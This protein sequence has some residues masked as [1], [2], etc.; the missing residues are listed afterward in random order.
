MSMAELRALKRRAGVAEEAVRIKKERL[1][2]AEQ[3]SETEKGKIRVRAETSCSTFPG[4]LAEKKTGPTGPRSSGFPA[5]TASAACA[6]TPHHLSMHTCPEPPSARGHCSVVDQDCQTPVGWSPSWWN[7]KGCQT[8]AAPPPAHA[9]ASTQMAGS[10]AGP[11]GAGAAGRASR[12][13]AGRGGLESLLLSK[14]LTTKDLP[15]AWSKRRKLDFERALAL[16]RDRLAAGDVLD[17]RERGL[18]AEMLF[19]DTNPSSF[20]YTTATTPK[21][22][23]LT[24]SQSQPIRH[25]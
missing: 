3:G 19:Q 21:T 10:D 1:D 15:R 17:N 6:F 24:T 8:S 18:V 14:P 22:T 20:H 25:T 13:S 5:S 2:E 7:S 12:G 11:V 16:V 23:A 4:N 9:H